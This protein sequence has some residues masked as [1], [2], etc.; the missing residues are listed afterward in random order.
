MAWHKIENPLNKHI[1]SLISVHYILHSRHWYAV[2]EFLCVFFFSNFIMCSC[3][4]MLCVLYTPLWVHSALLLMHFI[5][6]VCDTWSADAV[7]LFSM[8]CRAVRV[9]R[10]ATAYSYICV[11]SCNNLHVLLSL[12]VCVNMDFS[13]DWH[14]FVKVP[15]DSERLSD[16]RFAAN[17]SGWWSWILNIFPFSLITYVNW[18]AHN[19]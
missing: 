7:R 10:S 18:D 5:R 9:V 8:L 4:C 17:S 11:C 19:A 1:C 12:S 3:V 14:V 6:L 13:L 16:I 2:D 15:L